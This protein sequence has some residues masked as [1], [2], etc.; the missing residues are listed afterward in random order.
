MGIEEFD[1]EELID[2]ASLYPEFEE[3]F[4][5]LYVLKLKYCFTFWK[6]MTF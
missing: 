2:F 6:E 5:F 3:K 4:S 1:I